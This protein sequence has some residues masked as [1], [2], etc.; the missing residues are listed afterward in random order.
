MPNSSVSV[1]TAQPS[2]ANGRMQADGFISPVIP[3]VPLSTTGGHSQGP[4]MLP[5]GYLLPLVVGLTANAGGIQA[6]ATPITTAIAN[7]TTV[8]GNGYSGLLPA[9]NAYGSLVITVINSGANNLAVFPSGTDTINGGAAGASFIQAPGTVIT[10]FQSGAGQWTAAGIDDSP[11]QQAYN[12]NA[13]TGAIALSAANVTGAT[14]EVVLALTGAQ[15]GGVAATTP[16]GPAWIAAIQNAQAGDTYVLRVL[17]V[18][19]TQT[20]TFTANATG[21]TVTGTATIAN[22]TWREFLITV[23][24]ATTITAQNIGGGNVV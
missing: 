5:Q 11:V 12:T 8:G 15:S 7:F 20:I 1:Q 9:A 23:A 22:N 19:T 6:G 17:N 13:T 24:T 14:V 21:V 16:T 3:G 10:Y 18:G 4:A 2:A